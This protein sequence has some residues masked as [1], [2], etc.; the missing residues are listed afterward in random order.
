MTTGDLSSDNEVKKGAEDN[1]TAS[2]NT[3]SDTQNRSRGGYGR[4]RR[5]ITRSRE[6]IVKSVPVDRVKYSN[7][8]LLRECVTEGGKIHPR[9]SS[10]TP[11]KLQRLVKKAVKR[12]RFLGILP[13]TL[14]KRK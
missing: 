5:V 13:Y 10:N 4:G 7:L 11:A 2:T 8:K 1:N 3:S 14:K 12:A 6:S 9:R